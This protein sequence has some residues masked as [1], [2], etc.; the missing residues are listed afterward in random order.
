[1]VDPGED[2]GWCPLE[3]GQGR[4][5]FGK[6]WRDL[7]ARCAGTDQSDVFAGE[8]DVVVPRRSVPGMPA[9][10]LCVGQ[11]RDL[12]DAEPTDPEDEESARVRG[13]VIGVEGP[14]RGR[15][16]P[17]GPGHLCVEPD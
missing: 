7:H 17:T 4:R 13:A 14:F 10:R 12:R 9:E 1:M 8:V 11:L 6:V 15:I 5:T 16:V 3:D 2:P